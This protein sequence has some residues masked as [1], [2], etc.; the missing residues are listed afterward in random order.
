MIK[1]DTTVPEVNV[2]N[3]DNCHTGIVYFTKMH[4]LAGAQGERKSTECMNQDGCVACVSLIHLASLSTL[5]YLKNI[6]CILQFFLF[7]V[8][9]TCIY[10]KQ[11]IVF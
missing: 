10:V 1:S 11:C 2:V 5:E 8:I 9:S 6:L 3:N 7:S 4:S